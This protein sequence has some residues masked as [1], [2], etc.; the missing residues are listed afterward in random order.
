MTHRTDSAPGRQTQRGAALVIVVS[1]VG[2]FA[3]L[4]LSFTLTTR[5]HAQRSANAIRAIEAEALFASVFNLVVHDLSNRE[6]NQPVTFNAP[7]LTCTAGGASIVAVLGGENG[8]VNLNRADSELL[9][10]LIA[11]LS[12]P[13]DDPERLAESIIDYRD[14]DERT[15]QGV[16]ESRAYGVDDEVSMA[17][18]PFRLPDELGRVPTIRPELYWALRPHVTVHSA[19]VRPDAAAAAPDLVT[20]LERGS[21]SYFDRWRDTARRAPPSALGQALN[22]NTTVTFQNGAQFREERVFR[23]SRDRGADLLVRHMPLSIKARD[24]PPADKPC[25]H[26]G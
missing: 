10:A 16:N 14:T 17:N 12:E 23:L 7:I 18:R 22:L 5:F 9:A 6:P 13:P 26:I 1:F 25:P 11:G 8:K 19:G 15:A 4:A 2:I 24:I 3:A 20:I 21:W